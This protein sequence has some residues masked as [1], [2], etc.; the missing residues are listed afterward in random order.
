MNFKTTYILF[1]IFLG[2]FAIFA[3]TQIFGIKKPGETSA[4][5]LPSLNKE[6]KPASPDQFD[7]IEIVH[8]RPKEETFLFVKKDSGWE[9]QRPYRLLADSSQVSNLIR[10]VYSARKEKVDLGDNL[11]EYELDSPTTVVTLKK[12][13]DQEWKVALGRQSPG[14]ESQAMVYAT[15][16]EHPKKPMAVK[17]SDLELLFKPVNE[18]RSK[19]LLE[20]SALNTTYILFQEPKKEPIILD[21]NSEGVWRL[22]KPALGDADFEG[23]GTPGLAR[24]PQQ[25]KPITGVRDLLETVGAIRVESSADFETPHATDSELAQFGLEKDNPAYLRIEIKRTPGGL[26]G[27]TE[28][29][30]L[31]QNALLIGKLAE[32]KTASKED[33]K[34][35]EKKEEKKAGAKTEKRYVRLEGELAVA[36]VSAKTVESIFKVAANPAALRNR[37]LVQIEQARTDAIDITSSAGL[38]KLRKPMA[39]WKLYSGNG[40]PKAADDKA[41]YG[42]L[43]ALTERRQV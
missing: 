32:D 14:A 42:L 28:E 27:S 10:Q 12:G 24:D 15:S 4:Y 26:L 16:S 7:T 34:D 6:N 19:E 13:A 2:L 37:N 41:V 3:L 25:S 43:S 39:N 5:L 23:E 1:G 21:K 17:R 20:A 31:I 40:K 29:K 22:Q 11:K 38:L 18:F 36:K 9:M 33:K 30:N 35:S 8:Y